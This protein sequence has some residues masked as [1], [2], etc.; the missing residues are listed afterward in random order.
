MSSVVINPK[1]LASSEYSDSD[2]IIVEENPQYHPLFSSEDADIILCSQDGISF[3]VHSLALKLSSGWFRTLF[4]LPQNPSTSPP[5]STTHEPIHVTESSEVLNT[6]LSMACGFEIPRIHDIKY[7]EAL[8]HAAE[9]YDMPGALS[10]IR[11]ALVSPH[12]LKNHPIQVYAI[13]SRWDWQEEAE[14]A[15][16]YTVGMDLLSKEVIDKLRVVDP[17]DLTR[18]MLFHRKRRDQLK[19]GLDSQDIFYANIVPGRCQ[20]CDTPNMH[21]KWHRMKYDWVTG[22]EHRPMDASSR[23]L[24]ERMELADVLSATCIRCQKRLYNAESTI[25]NLRQILEKLPKHVEFK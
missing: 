11:L 2:A 22:F 23:D 10:I 9:K 13:A 21:E 18:L 7:L 19:R 16:S 24:L 17:P 5:S 15:S 12:F 25:S 20:G 1:D 6:I 4:T 3:R 8:V 14:I